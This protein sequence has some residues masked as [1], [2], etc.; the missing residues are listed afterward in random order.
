MAGLD[1]A[2]DC[3]SDGNRVDR[4]AA[5]NASAST[6]IGCGHVCTGGTAAAAAAAAVVVVAV[7][8]AAVAAVCGMMGCDIG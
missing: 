5:S 7:G 6:V 1:D 4:C 3:M 2:T 8:V